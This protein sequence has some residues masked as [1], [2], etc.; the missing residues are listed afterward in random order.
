VQS[1][2]PPASTSTPVLSSTLPP[3]TTPCV[4][5]TGSPNIFLPADPTGFY[6]FSS[7]PKN[8]DLDTIGQTFTP[9][10][11]STITSFSFDLR[12]LGGNSPVSRL[13]HPKPCM[14][15]LVKAQIPTRH[16]HASYRCL[17]HTLL[18]CAQDCTLQ[19]FVYVFPEVQSSVLLC[20]QDF[21]FAAY[22]YAWDAIRPGPIEPQLFAAA[23]TS[24]PT[25]GAADTFN[26]PGCLTLSASTQYVA[27]LSSAGYW[28]AGGTELIDNVLPSTTSPLPNENIALTHAGNYTANFTTTALWYYPPQLENIPNLAF[29][30][31]YA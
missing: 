29:N 3:P 7:N 15:P 9:T 14:M 8:G 31:T 5:K 28:L 1:T 24:V 6:Y 11:D 10:A 27:F 30:V 20:A 18:H 25:D 13:F 12:I 22:L 26:V 2:L 23:P 16:D 19:T 4:K 17:L 21:I